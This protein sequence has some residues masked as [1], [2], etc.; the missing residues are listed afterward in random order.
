[1]QRRTWISLII[2]VLFLTAV[3]IYLNNVFLPVKVKSLLV[4]SLQQQ[5]QKRVSLRN[6]KLNIFKGLVLEELAISDEQGPMINLRE[7]SC[8]FLIPAIFK[9]TIII[10]SVRLKSPTVFL[11]RRQ[12]NTFNLQE[13]FLKKAKVIKKG[14][15]NISV[16]KITVQ[17]GVVKFQDDT[18]KTPFNKNIEGINLTLHLSLPASLKFN[19]R[20]A[21]AGKPPAIINATGGYQITEGELS[22]RAVINNF[23]PQD[24]V[25]YCQN[26]AININSGLIDSAINLKFKEKKSYLDLDMRG[27]NLNI[28]KDKIALKLNAQLKANLQ[29]G[30]KFSQLQFNGQGTIKDS[31]IAGLETIGAIKDI[32]TDFSL[33]KAGISSPKLTASV[34]GIPLQAK[35]TL[36][37][38]TNPLLS[39]DAVSSLDLTSAQAI[40]KDKLRFSFPGEIQ[41]E[42]KLALDMQYRL[43]ANAMQLAG[44]LDIANASL[45]LE[46]LAAPLEKI[47]GRLELIQDKIKW[48]ELNFQ[49][50]GL[51]YKSRGSVSSFRPLAV[52]LE[53]VSKDLFLKGGFSFSGNLIKLTS[54]SGKYLNSA[55]A[56][57]GSIDIANLLNLTGQIDAGLNID[58]RDLKTMFPKYQDRLS[59]IDL[60]GLIHVQLGIEGDL[61]DLKSSTLE[62]KFSSPA[63]SGYGLEAQDFFLNYRQ[64]EAQAEISLMRLSLYDGT[65]ELTAKM[66]L[67]S[68][69]FP[70]WLTLDLQG[71]RLEKLKLDTA[72]KDK[73][74]AGILQAQAKI[75]GFAKDILR[76]NG[77]GRINISEGKLWELNLFQGL[78]KLLFTKDFAQ[79]TFQEGSCG[80]IIRDKYISTDNLR[81]KS[82][83]TDLSGAVK[84]GFDNSLA[85]S[86]NVEVLDQTLPLSGTFQDVAKA[87]I[88][89]AGRFGEIKIS[90]T[91][92]EPKYKFEPQVTDIL[93]GLKDTIFGK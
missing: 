63:V 50:L 10:P 3:I 60:N 64:K 34:W 54:L 11:K 21:I 22:L 7:A 88:G 77:E 29:Y 55:F 31:E 67:N 17:G 52:D 75:N 27:T 37:N 38:F 72:A 43:S 73:D 32:N 33:D 66:N 47:H 44:Y 8:A 81:L 6:L 87:I 1:M 51:P 74:L 28:I 42:A 65:A 89:K 30:P 70:F 71:V 41:G 15:F 84:I 82:N 91:L 79:I 56:A 85:A 39:I 92:K 23:A 59:Q 83:L 4:T 57:D 20:A 62:A 35:L 80:F 25:S 24:F 61:N 78:G 12:D 68:E 48:P 45:K 2:A 16:L 93:Q 86:L 58:L 76:L 13:L 46:K 36:G 69:N 53:L 49:Y 18:L 19:L 14:G 5:T 26:F 9:K 90:G 40:L